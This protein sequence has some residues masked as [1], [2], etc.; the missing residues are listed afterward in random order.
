MTK[1]RKSAWPHPADLLLVGVLWTAAIKGLISAYPKA[2]E[3]GW[4]HAAFAVFMTGVVAY[5]TS[6][7][8]TSW[9]SLV[10][11]W[12]I[13]AWMFTLY[14]TLGRLGV[15]AVGDQTFDSVLARIDEALLGFDPSYEVQ[16][17]LTP[18]RVELF[19]IAYA[20]FIPYIHLALFLN[21]ESRGGENRERFLTGWTLLYALSYLGYLF[22]PA[23]GPAAFPREHNHT[24]LQGGFFFQLVRDSVAASGGLFGVFPS[25]HIGCSVFL[26]Y[27]IGIAIDCGA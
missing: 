24:E 23:F 1:E 5:D 4:L 22:V 20:W 2:Q 7:R 13:V 15:A 27:S 14:S 18:R 3:L 6:K 19:A 17:Y 8:Q 16:R 10:R 21:L 25:L 9:W 12:A 11:P 26:C